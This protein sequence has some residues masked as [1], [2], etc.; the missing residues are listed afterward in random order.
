MLLRKTSDKQVIA[1]CY[2]FSVARERDEE[3]PRGPAPL[4][5]RSTVFRTKP[6]IHVDMGGRVV[7]QQPMQQQHQNGLHQ[8]HLQQQHH[9]LTAA[10]QQRLQDRNHG[11]Y[12]FEATMSK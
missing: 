9:A 7:Q 8:Q 1:T 5:P 4:S 2:S 10:N 12:H 11:D 3:T 6:V